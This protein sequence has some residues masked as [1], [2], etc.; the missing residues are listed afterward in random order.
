[1]IGMHPATG[2]NIEHTLNKI[3]RHINAWSVHF[4]A[5]AAN[6]RPVLAEPAELVE[7]VSGGGWSEQDSK[8]LER[9]A[10]ALERAFDGTIFNV[11]KSSLDI[12]TLSNRGLQDVLAMVL[13]KIR[14]QRR[15]PEEGADTQPKRQAPE[16][17]RPTTGI[18]SK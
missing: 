12:S 1:M 17:P 14:S 10:T 11:N 4:R 6:S 8:Q 3:E 7:C 13:E 2:V 18:M 16:I 5:I 15:D 9:I